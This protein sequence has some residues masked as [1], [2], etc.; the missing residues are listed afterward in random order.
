ML[1]INPAFECDGNIPVQTLMQERVYCFSYK[2]IKFSLG[3]KDIYSKS[4]SE[5]L[6]PVV[7]SHLIDHSEH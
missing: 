7:A 5:K 6:N 2:K 3:G 1:L 4:D